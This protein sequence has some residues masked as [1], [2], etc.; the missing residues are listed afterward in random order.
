MTRRPNVIVDLGRGRC[1][2]IKN[3]ILSIGFKVAPRIPCIVLPFE[4]TERLAQAL[5]SVPTADTSFTDGAG[6]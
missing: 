6:I 2:Q 4:C 5:A 1:A 3:G